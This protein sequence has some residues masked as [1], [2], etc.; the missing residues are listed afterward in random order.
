MYSFLEQEKLSTVLIQEQESDESNDSD[1]NSMQTGNNT[2]IFGVCSLLDF[3]KLN[4]AP[5][6]SIIHKHIWAKL[7]EKRNSIPSLVIKKFI[8]VLGDDNMTKS[9][10]SMPSVG[11]IINERFVNLPPQ[12]SLRMFEN[13]QT[14]M[15]TA[16]C[17]FDFFLMIINMLAATGTK[18]YQNFK[19]TNFY[20]KA[21]E[22]LIDE[23]AKW[24]FV[25]NLDDPGD[26]LLQE[27]GVEDVAQQRKVVLF[28]SSLF[29]D[30]LKKMQDTL[31]KEEVNE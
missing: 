25:Y 19:F 20:M 3:N 22:E 26:D 24:S 28:E 9:K 18:T 15:K 2:V 16:A 11:F 21:E 27:S 1:D 31:K 10:K 8:E 13:L 29:P 7:N 23:K 30:I 14:E 12:G 6:I 4:A 17:K 5:C